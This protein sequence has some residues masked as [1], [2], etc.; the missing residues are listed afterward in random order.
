MPPDASATASRTTITAET[1]LAAFR[2]RHRFDTDRPSARPWLYGIVANLIGKHRCGDLPAEPQKWFA[3]ALAWLP[4]PKDELRAEQQRYWVAGN[5]LGTPLATPDGL[6]KLYRALA[7]IDGMRAV[8]HLVTDATG[9]KAIALYLDDGGRTREELL[10]DPRTYRYVGQRA[11]HVKDAKP[12]PGHPDLPQY[13]AGDVAGNVAIV[14][15][16]LVDREGRRP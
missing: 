10:I 2:Q 11:V 12:V 8:D 3:E 1:F 13:E 6:A 15:V 7:E 5:L 16:A 9:D 4:P 14:E